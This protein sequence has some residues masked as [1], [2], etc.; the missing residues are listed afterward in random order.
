MFPTTSLTSSSQKASKVGC[1]ELGLGIGCS[2]DLDGEAPE[3]P[4]AAPLS[5][6]FMEPLFINNSAFEDAL[7]SEPSTTASSPAS[8]PS[9]SARCPFA[10]MNALFEQLSDDGVH[11]QAPLLA[12][13]S[14]SLVAPL[15]LSS[16]EIL[17]IGNSAFEDAPSSEPTAAIASPSFAGC[18]LCLHINGLFDEPRCD[19]V[20]ASPPPSPCSPEGADK[21]PL[22]LTMEQLPSQ[23]ACCASPNLTAG[24]NGGA[25]AEPL[26]PPQQ[27]EAISV[28]R[29]ESAATGS[30]PPR[31]R[32]SQLPPAARLAS[33]RAMEVV[34]SPPPPS[35][36]LRKV[37]K[38]SAPP[39]VPV[40]PA[41]VR[42]K[43]HRQ[44]DVTAPSLKPAARSQRQQQRAVEA[45]SV[46]R[47]RWR[48]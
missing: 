30:L 36:G 6:R 24:G 19:D 16:L 27:E 32:Q 17:L 47:P 9:F 38:A 11:Q 46:D 26:D 28:G 20:G 21:A 14:E 33:R 13:A 18:C 44:P 41:A 22:H 29:Q 48:S 25:A 34:R 31:C 4:A 45:A 43:A 42:P 5:P 10:R 1:P 39:A 23:E 2:W 8:S 12:E 35:S 37:A 7:S 40:R 15:S 3:P